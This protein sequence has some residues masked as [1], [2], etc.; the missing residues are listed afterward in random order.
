MDEPHSRG[1]LGTIVVSVIIGIRFVAA[2][3]FLVAFSNDLRTWA[4]CIFLVAVLS[5]AAD[6]L[7]VRRLGGASPL[8]GAY[9]DPVA[10][11]ALVV[12]AFAAFVL[13]DLYPGWLLLLIVAMFAQFVL[14]SRLAGPIYDPVGKYYGVFLYAAASLTV[15][16][17]SAGARRVLLVLIVGLTV[18][19]VIS[20]TLFLLGSLMQRE[21]GRDSPDPLREEGGTLGK[22]GRGETRRGAQVRDSDRGVGSLMV[23]HRHGLDS[24]Q[25]A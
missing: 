9:S 14:T 6:G 5:D 8:I 13:K 1:Q 17:R 24:D 12:A 10:D 7:V 25:K 19:S 16:L 21:P 15:L 3:L 4:L 18:A 20:R 11:F 2:P 22:H 23:G